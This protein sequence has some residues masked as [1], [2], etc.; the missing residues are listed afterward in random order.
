M[1]TG[2]RSLD[3]PFGHQRLVFGLVDI[4]QDVI[5]AALLNKVFNLSPVH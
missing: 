2:A 1:Q 4:E 5:V 3:L